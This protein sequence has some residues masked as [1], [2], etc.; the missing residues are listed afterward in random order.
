[1][2]KRFIKIAQGS[3]GDA[4]LV[5]VCSFILR[6]FVFFTYTKSFQEEFQ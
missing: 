1:M 3:V 4:Q 2:L 6:A 5:M